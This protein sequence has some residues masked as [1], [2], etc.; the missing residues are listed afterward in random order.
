MIPSG[1][2]SP[3]SGPLGASTRPAGA[4]VM[5]T[6]TGD[7]TVEIFDMF[8]TS[9][10]CMPPTGFVAMTHDTYLQHYVYFPA[11]SRDLNSTSG[12]SSRDR[13]LGQL[14]QTIMLRQGAWPPESCW[15]AERESCGLQ[16]QHAFHSNYNCC[17]KRS[18]TKDPM[19][20]S[21]RHF[22]NHRGNN[23]GFL[24]PAM[25]FSCEDVSWRKNEII[26][27]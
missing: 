13:P 5:T 7:R 15:V 9:S 6:C 3:I 20:M 26:L 10:T 24:C 4:A 11:K 1:A 2:C 16:G 14:I 27:L 22:K 19:T 17:L 25:R 18:R 21:H 8:H 12:T 23:R